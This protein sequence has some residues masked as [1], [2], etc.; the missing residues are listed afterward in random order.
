MK[1][2]F[3]DSALLK[4][5]LRNRLGDDFLNDLLLGFLENDFVIKILDNENLREK[6]GDNFRNL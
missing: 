1:V 5:K 4:K 2:P 3:I 6:I